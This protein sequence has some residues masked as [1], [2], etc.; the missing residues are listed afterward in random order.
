MLDLDEELASVLCPYLLQLPNLLYT[1]DDC[2]VQV[3]GSADPLGSASGSNNVISEHIHDLRWM[4]ES[5]A[6]D[7][8]ACIIDPQYVL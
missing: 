2:Y 3:N 8:V 1:L 4:L 7:S 6:R 5:R